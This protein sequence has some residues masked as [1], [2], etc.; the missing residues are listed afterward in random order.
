MSVTEALGWAL[1]H[2]LWQEALAAATLASLLAIVPARA[3]RIRYG[4]AAVTL[5]VMLALPLATGLRLHAVA[6]WPVVPESPAA[7]VAAARLRTTIEPTLPWIVLV[8][9]GGVLVLSLRLTSG[10]LVA[11]RLGRTATHPVPEACRE[12]LARLAA[13]LRVSRPVRVLESAVVQVPAVVGWLRP[14]IL[15]PASALTGLTPQQ[16]DVLLAHELAHVRRYDYLVNLVQSAIEILLFYHPAVR[17]VS[18]RVREEREHCCDDLAVAVCGDAHL[19]AR[20]LLMMES[21]R[22]KTPALALSA[23][24][25]Q[26][27]TLLGRVRR[28]VAPTPVEPV[29]RWMAGVVGATLLL[30]LGGGAALV[31]A[32]A[33]A[34]TDTLIAFAQTL[35]NPSAREEAVERLGDTRDP[36]ALAPLIAIVRDDHD[37]HV[38]REAVEALGELAGAGGGAAL[39]NVART[40]PNASV[41]RKA[42]K[43]LTKAFAGAEVVPL[44]ATIART[45]PEEEVQ[46]EALKSLAKMKHGAGLGAL[47][48]IAHTHPNPEVRE[49]ARRRLRYSTAAVT[50]SARTAVRD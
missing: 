19:Y 34:A 50:L 14:V 31:G 17:W 21:L 37:H 6:A 3:A 41:R 40:H 47:S 30:G 23:A 35:E 28:L 2:S 29:P 7:A 9:F 15:L 12:A 22:A 4:L 11:R 44:L 25:T 27:G 16:L 49:A 20:A 33:A 45:D 38:Q 36:R 26:G 46:E 48:D 42:I 24:G 32:N 43:E 39:V 10:W 5:V 1:L 18:R 8:W 13:R